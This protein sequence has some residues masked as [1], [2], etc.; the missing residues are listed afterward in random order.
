MHRPS[1]SKMRNWSIT[2]S[3]LS[4]TLLVAITLGLY[5][6][7]GSGL[8]SI[9]TMTVIPSVGAPILRSCWAFERTPRATG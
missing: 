2:L 8:S 1:S 4:L 6:L 3:S 7:V 5:L 9:H